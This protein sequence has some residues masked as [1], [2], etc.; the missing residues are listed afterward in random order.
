[1]KYNKCMTDE[2]KHLYYEDVYIFKM[3]N[4][5]LS[6]SEEFSPWHT[7]YYKSTVLCTQQDCHSISDE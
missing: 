5:A 1:M 2:T 3:T 4:F 6:I 7:Y